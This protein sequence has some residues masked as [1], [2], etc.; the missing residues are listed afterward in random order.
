MPDLKTH[1]PY[2][3]LCILLCV[4]LISACTT[5]PY[6][7][8]KSPSISGQIYIDQLPAEGINI[9][10]STKSA[11][12]SCRTTI[13]KLRTDSSGNFHISPI[14][15]KMNYTP[16][17]TYYLDEWVVCADIKGQRIGIYSGDRYGTGGVTGRVSITCHFN[18]GQYTEKACKQNH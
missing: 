13:E 15:E 8:Y 10:L 14:K 3:Q 17:M 7:R 11:D 12:K 1:K 9:Y 16:L 18:P 2:F 6:T 5:T 4:G